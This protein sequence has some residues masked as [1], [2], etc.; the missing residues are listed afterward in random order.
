MAN[1]A[2]G[3]TDCYISIEVTCYLAIFHIIVQSSIAMCIHICRHVPNS[4]KMACF[5][6][7]R[8]KTAVFLVGEYL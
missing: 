5:M 2:Q 7:L 1:T 8:N 4:V 6:V 3:E